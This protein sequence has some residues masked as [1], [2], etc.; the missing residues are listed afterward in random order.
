M[1]N[2]SVVFLGFKNNTIDETQKTIKWYVYFFNI[3]L[4]VQTRDF[5]IFHIVKKCSFTLNLN[6]Q[7]EKV[8]FELGFKICKFLIFGDFTTAQLFLLSYKKHVA[9]IKLW[10]FSNTFYYAAECIGQF[11]W[12]IMDKNRNNKK[13][14]VNYRFY[15]V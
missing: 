1:Y 13:Y 11:Y 4:F 10:N 15:G 7:S 3:P 9:I 2:L 6:R 14:Y 8:A 5:C 12:T